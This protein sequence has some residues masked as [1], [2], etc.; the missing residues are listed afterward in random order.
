VK[1]GVITFKFKLLGLSRVPQGGKE[2]YDAKIKEEKS[3]NDKVCYKCS[4]ENG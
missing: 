3:K 1:R 2:Q 4:R